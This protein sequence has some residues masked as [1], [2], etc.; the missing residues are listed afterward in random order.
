LGPRSENFR[1]AGLVLAGTGDTQIRQ[2]AAMASTLN[3]TGES[4]PV[5]NKGHGTEALGPSDLSDTGSDV[6]IGPGAAQDP[7]EALPLDHGT[8][9]DVATGARE[10][11]GPDLGDADLDSDTDATGTGE[12]ASAGRDD[13]AEAADIAPDNATLDDIGAEEP[14]EDPETD[15]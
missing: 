2:E 7:S 10:T 14:E 5:I 6:K 4:R 1:A 12:R 11:A 15:A 13:T 8:T 9:S 3:R